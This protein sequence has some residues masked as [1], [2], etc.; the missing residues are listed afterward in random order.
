MSNHDD[1]SPSVV[2]EQDQ[3]QNQ[4]QNQQ[5]DQQQDPQPDQQDE[6]EEVKAPFEGQKLMGKCGCDF[7][8]D[9][10][11]TTHNDAVIDCVF[12]LCSLGLIIAFFFFSSYLSSPL[13]KMTH[14]RIMEFVFI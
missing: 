8:R 9:G 3:Q 4:Q 11:A 13:S 12:S 6:E 1:T 2:T 10:L 14:P 5:Q 7:C